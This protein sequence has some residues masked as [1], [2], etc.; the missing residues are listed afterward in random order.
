MDIWPQFS[1]DSG[2]YLVISENPASKS[3]FR[4]CQMAVWDQLLS[5][6]QTP[7]CQATRT[8]G[9]GLEEVGNLASGGGVGRTGDV[10][11]A[12]GTALGGGLLP[13]NST[14]STRNI[15]TGNALQP[16]L[17]RNESQSLISTSAPES[18]GSILTQFPTVA[19]QRISESP[20][21]QD[22][23]VEP[24]AEASLGKQTTSTTEQK[25]PTRAVTPLLPLLKPP[26][27]PLFGNI[28]G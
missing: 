27:M 13:A 23:L 18:L 6:L 21:I 2:N 15:L 4:Y 17:G 28:L 26:K 1:E 16:L 22:N 11:G 10:L 12:L 14:N 3:G 8:L 9:S 20:V 25:P 19:I 24:D 5:R 7:L